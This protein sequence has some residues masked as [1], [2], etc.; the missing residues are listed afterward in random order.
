MTT[1][2]QKGS[3]LLTNATLQNVADP[4]STRTNLAADAGADDQALG[5]R[6]QLRDTWLS[7]PIERR[8]AAELLVR[9]TNTLAVE[10]HDPPGRLAHVPFDLQLVA[11]PATAVPEP[12]TWTM[13]SVLAAVVL[14]FAWWRRR[15]RAAL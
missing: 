12:A 9:G 15:R 6:P 13:L 14:A 1:A 7:F 4:V 10:V 8:V 2:R 3:S 5:N 11:T